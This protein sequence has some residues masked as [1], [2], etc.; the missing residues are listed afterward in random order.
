M[1]I[2]I[3][4]PFMLL[5]IVAFVIVMKRILAR[6][7]FINA[8]ILAYYDNGEMSKDELIDQ[9]YKYGCLDFR[10]KKIVAKYGATREDY[11]KIFLKLKRYANMKKRHRYIPINSFFFVSSLE[12]LLK[13]KDAPDQQLAKKMMNHFHF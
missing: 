2:E 12:Y 8:L 1:P 13:H 4:V 11:E 5:M 9:M 7:N 3:Y 6:D 10:L